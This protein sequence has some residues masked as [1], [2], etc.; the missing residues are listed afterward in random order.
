MKSE[1]KLEVYDRMGNELIYDFEPRKCEE[2]V[3]FVIMRPDPMWLGFRLFE[4]RNVSTLLSSLPNMKR[5][6]HVRYFFK[7]T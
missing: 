1:Q 7:K 5:T 6:N 2:I 3:S 4:K